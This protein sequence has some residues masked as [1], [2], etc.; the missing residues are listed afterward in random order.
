VEIPIYTVIGSSKDRVVY[1]SDE[2][3][4]LCPWALD[5]VNGDR[6]RLTSEPVAS[7]IW[8]LP[9]RTTNDF[10][11]P[12]DA[13]KGAEHHKI[14]KANCLEGQ[15]VLAVDVPEMRVNMLA[16]Y[17]DLVAFTAASKDSAGLFTSESGKIEKRADLGG[18]TFVNDVNENFVAGM[19]VLSGNPRAYELFFFDL[20]SNQMEVY[21]PKEGSVNKGPVL[22]GSM[23]LFESNASG[24]ND[25]Y[26]HDLE[27]D[28]T[29]RAPLGSPDQRSFH[30]T[31]HP[32]FD[33]TDDGKVFCVAKKDG[34]ARAFID[35]KV[36]ETPPGYISG[37]ALHGREAYFSQSTF[38]QP[39]RV[40]EVNLRT[41]AAKT[42]IDNPLPSLL[43]DR[44]VRRRLVR[45]NS[46]DGKEIAAYVADD[47]SAE[48]RRTVTY[49]HGGPWGEVFDAWEIIAAALVAFGY[50]VIAPNYRGSTGYGED[51]RN[52]DV[53]D[54]GGMDFVDMAQATW[55]AKENIATDVALVG[56]SYGGYGTLYGLGKEP[57][58]WACGVAGAPVADWKEMYDTS[59]ATFRSFIDIL[60]DRKTELLVERSPIT[61]VKNVKKP[62]CIISSQ[63]DSRTPMM[64]V[65]RYAMAL[66]ANGAKFE[67]H[68]V[69]DMGHAIRTT[70]DIMDIVYPMI[71]F[72][73]KEFPSARNTRS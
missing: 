67:L 60:F 49:I 8:A 17:G 2:G 11:Y 6:R 23:A 26:V 40:L 10:Y 19:G 58:L 27:T 48:R 56:Y 44:F 3:G 73:Q 41:G 15:E 35:G 43:R 29:V 71:A 65:L 45:Y 39:F 21:T 57:E 33:W 24:D 53:G 66:Q 72:L 28:E 59:D 12:R 22:R 50:N 14:F 4:I 32:I 31:E 62:L 68:S 9:R 30:P 46:T 55:W 52:L 47:G 13:A 37:M 63:N 34:Q 7:Q 16:Y 42:V 20:G 54:P 69:P 64:P 18:F 38:V 1:Y 25:L 51:F 61:Y 5:P 36:V 70:K